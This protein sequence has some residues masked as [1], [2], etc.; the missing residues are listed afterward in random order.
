MNIISY[1]TFKSNDEFVKW[2]KE[3]KPKILNV[4]PVYSKF[5]IES[6]DG[7]NGST[8]VSEP[9]IFVTYIKEETD[10]EPDYN[11]E[12]PD[13]VTSNEGWLSYKI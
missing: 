5:D 6:E 1:I 8:N 3:N 2:Q 7:C 12:A 10:A 11:T 4:I 13:L 9:G